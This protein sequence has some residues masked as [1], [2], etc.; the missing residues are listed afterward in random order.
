MCMTQGMLAQVER[1]R[2]KVNEA[3]ELMALIVHVQVQQPPKITVFKPLYLAVAVLLCLLGIHLTQ[4]FSGS[5][6]A[7]LRFGTRPSVSLRGSGTGSSTSSFVT[8]NAATGPR[9]D[10]ALG[11]PVRVAGLVGGRRAGGGGGG[12]RAAKMLE[13]LAMSVMAVSLCDSVVADLRVRAGKS[14]A[15]RAR[16]RARKDARLAVGRAAADADVVK[17]HLT[18]LGAVEGRSAAGG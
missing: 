1:N 4:A 5:A 6:T 15:A 9:Q 8:P 16:A 17:L 10:S 7:M 14:V 13:P 18:E 12:L 2:H 11:V 3:H